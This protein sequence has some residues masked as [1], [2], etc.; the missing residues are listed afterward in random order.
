MMSSEAGRLVSELNQVPYGAPTR[1]GGPMRIWADS[2]FARADLEEAVDLWESAIGSTRQQLVIVNDA[3]AANVRFRIGPVPNGICGYEG[4]TLIQNHVILAG[5]G[6]YSSAQSCTGEGLAART[7][8]AHGIGHILGVA[9]HTAAA[10]DIMS[11]TYSLFSVS[12]ALAEAMRYIYSTSLPGVAAGSAGS[13]ASTPAATSTPLP[14]RTPTRPPTFTP[15]ALP[16]STPT[17]IPTN[18][19]EAPLSTPSDVE[20]PQVTG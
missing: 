12:P 3:E 20:Q 9:G 18:A 1:W 8:L 5:E 16:T 4:P 6:V 11:Q 17:V 13:A 2:G 15:T 14:T 7:A 10:T 19:P